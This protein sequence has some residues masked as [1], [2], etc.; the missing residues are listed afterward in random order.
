MD[1]DSK[2]LLRAL[3][4]SDPEI[5]RFIAEE[6]RWYERQDAMWESFAQRK[7]PIQKPKKLTFFQKLKKY[8][9]NQ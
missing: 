2:D 4:K 1:E 5:C 9:C 8:V 7:N 3:Y 6:M